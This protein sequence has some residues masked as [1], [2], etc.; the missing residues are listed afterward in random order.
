MSSIEKEIKA[1]KKCLQTLKI[2]QE[3]TG[4]EQN[5]AIELRQLTLE[6]GLSQKPESSDILF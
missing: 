6:K 2:E 3:W 5:I 4:R 1:I